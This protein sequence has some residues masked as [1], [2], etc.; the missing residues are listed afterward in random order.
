VAQGIGSLPE[1]SLNDDTVDA[2]AA[3]DGVD[4]VVA[5]NQT[6][7]TPADGVE[8]EVAGPGGGGSLA[9]AVADIDGL[10]QAYDFEV[11]AGSLDDVAGT[12]VIIDQATAD[13]GDLAVGD[14]LAV[15]A[16]SGG[17]ELEVAAIVETSLPGTPQ[18]GIIGDT[19]LSVALGDTAPATTVY[20][21]GDASEE[22]LT[23]AI[24]LP[25]IDVLST[26]DY[27]DGLSSNLDTILALVYALLAVAVIIALVGIA[28][29]VSLAISERVGEIAAIRAAGASSRQIFWSLIS[30]FGLLALVGVLSGLALAWVSATAFFQALS[31]GQIT[32]P[33]TDLVT[34]VL[35]V[36]AGLAGGA[37]ASWFPA[38]SAS[39]SDI[40]DVLRAD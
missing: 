25:T 8:I 12:S 16:L 6:T 13:A 23:A 34:G 39:R 3:V 17:V 9:T 19:D 37:L 1:P 5:I 28:N 38:R 31:E 18:P 33:E 26:D 32:Y 20:I 24:D 36:L 14:T 2:L 10:S 40:L 35:I 21:V 27:I 7:V 22:A 29:T 4:L 15:T 11:N 30:E